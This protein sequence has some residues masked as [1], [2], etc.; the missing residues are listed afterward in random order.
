MNLNISII[1]TFWTL[2]NA[3]NPFNS[4]LMTLTPRGGLWTFSAVLALCVLHQKKLT[5]FPNLFSRP[6]K[7][8]WESYQSLW[9]HQTLIAVRCRLDTKWTPFRNPS[10]YFGNCRHETY[11]LWKT[12]SNFEQCSSWN[13]Y[14][15]WLQFSKQVMYIMKS[16]LKWVS[17]TVAQANYHS[18]K[19]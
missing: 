3:L 19:I 6:F 8:W 17:S 12:A 16:V 9:I 5:N 11:W 4:K 2:I 1:F 10:I 13:C 7:F 14:T 18:S 15:F